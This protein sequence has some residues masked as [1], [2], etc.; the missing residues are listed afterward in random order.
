MDISER[1]V[2]PAPPPLT[3]HLTRF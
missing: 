3:E 2:I 1:K